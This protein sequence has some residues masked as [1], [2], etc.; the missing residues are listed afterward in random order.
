MREGETEERLLSDSI[1][2][3][4]DSDS[5]DELV[6]RSILLA[7]C[8]E[9]GGR[10][11]NR[12]PLSLLPRKNR[13]GRSRFR[14]F[15]PDSCRCS[16]ATNRERGERRRR[17]TTRTLQEEEGRQSQKGATRPKM[18]HDNFDKR[19]ENITP[20]LISCGLLAN[21]TFLET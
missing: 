19:P 20:D 18:S 2:M 15:A 13:Q 16:F 21:F 1:T 12:R 6:G 5:E 10:R 14:F 3:N 7:L 11:M 4:D 9:M 8:G 17:G